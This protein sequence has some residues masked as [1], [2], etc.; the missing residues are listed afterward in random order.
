[1]DGRM[2]EQFVAKLGVPK[3]LSK[4][5]QYCMQ[6][7]TISAGRT[8][9]ASLVYPQVKIC[10]CIELACRNLSG[11]SVE[12]SLLTKLAGIPPRQY[13]AAFT[14]A[15]SVLKIKDTVT[16]QQLCVQFSCTQHTSK[17]S[18]LYSAY[19]TKQNTRQREMGHE[20]LDFSSPIFKCAAIIAAAKFSRGKTY[21][22]DFCSTFSITAA[23]IEPVIREMMLC[24]ELLQA[25][26]EKESIGQ[27]V[28]RKADSLDP[29]PGN[30]LQQT[31]ELVLWK[32]SSTGPCHSAFNPEFLEWKEK[33]IAKAS[34]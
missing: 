1:M 23:K 9:H 12:K 32:Y 17:A 28:A 14:V 30:I 27:M 15:E 6:L 4:A 13:K 24:E 21:Q 31:K 20:P 7:E 16:I 5:Q 8:L 10:I 33:M 18:A 11:C 19:S 2:M 26:G 34:A 25:E 29:L 22:K 3:C